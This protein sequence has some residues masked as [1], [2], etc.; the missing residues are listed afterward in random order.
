[1]MGERYADFISR[2]SQLGT[3][4][5]QAVKNIAHARIVNQ[6]GLFEAAEKDEDIS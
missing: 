3:G 4:Y 5:R 6:G 2:K 1:M